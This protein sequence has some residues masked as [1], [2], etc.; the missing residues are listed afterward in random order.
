MNGESS[1]VPVTPS[2]GGLPSAMHL[3]Y[4]AL[5][6]SNRNFRRLWLAQLISEMG[7]WF[8]MLAIYDLLLARTHRGEAVGWAII[9]GTL[10]WFFMTPF[11]GYVADRCR[12]RS[13]A[14]CW[15]T[16]AAAMPG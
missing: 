8:Y 14:S 7:D 10:P 3:R 16:W 15:G 11:A 2:Q 6:R 1:P 13:C 4:L 5:L 9:I 12:R